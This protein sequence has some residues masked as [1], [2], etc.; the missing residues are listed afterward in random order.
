MSFFKNSGVIID[1]N[2]R[3][4]FIKKEFEK[5]SKKKIL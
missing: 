1:H 5:I 2:L 3:K 4:E